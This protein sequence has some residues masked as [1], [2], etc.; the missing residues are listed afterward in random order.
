M[1]TKIYEGYLEY[2]RYFRRYFLHNRLSLSIG[3][4]I[5]I[6]NLIV[7][8]CSMFLSELFTDYSL[9]LT[10]SITTFASSPF[11]YFFI[12]RSNRLIPTKNISVYLEGNKLSVFW[13]TLYGS[14]FAQALEINKLIYVKNFTYVEESKENYV[15]LPYAL[16]NLIKE[17]QSS[18]SQQ[19]DRD[20][21]NTIDNV[22][23]CNL[24]RKEYLKFKNIRKIFTF[25][26]I[27]LAYLGIIIGYTLFYYYLNNMYNFKHFLCVMTVVALG[28][29]YIIAQLGVLSYYCGGY[30]P[31]GDVTIYSEYHDLIFYWKNKHNTSMCKRI[32]VGDIQHRGKRIFIKESFTNSV[33]LPKNVEHFLSNLNYRL[34]S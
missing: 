23:K 2:W 30:Q 17:H 6:G 20:V 25:V 12:I 4:G 24:N 9:F 13:K 14:Y 15:Y 21:A 11:C 18:L 3:Y 10:L 22:F 8:F 34:N 1:G 31:F 5:V 7:I 19:K 32:S 33:Y 26:L 27:A 28:N 29:I 16:L